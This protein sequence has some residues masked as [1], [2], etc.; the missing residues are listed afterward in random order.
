[1][2]SKF[3]H[4]ILYLFIFCKSNFFKFSFQMKNTPVGKVFD[5][6]KT[7]TPT[8]PYTTISFQN[9]S[10]SKFVSIQDFNSPQPPVVKASLF[11]ED[12]ENNKPSRVINSMRNT[13]NNTNNNTSRVVNSTPHNKP[14][15]RLSVTLFPKTQDE[16][17]VQSKNSTRKSIST[18]KSMQPKNDLTGR[19]RESWE[20]EREHEVE[21]EKVK[22]RE[23]EFRLLS[24]TS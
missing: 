9:G 7:P 13:R 20:R 5:T 19:L 16:K 22:E 6:K 21:V 1:M 2:N 4:F 23:K 3:Y 11:P 15:P 14:T 10:N 17:L 18:R 24:F 12:E 8:I